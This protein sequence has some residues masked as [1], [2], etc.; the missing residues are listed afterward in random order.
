MI[1]L[2]EGSG[3][4]GFELTK[5]AV[6]DD[7]WAQLKATAVKLLAK[8][9]QGRA[10]EFLERYPFELHD[11]TNYFG[12]EFSVLYLSVG[13]E[14]YVQFEDYRRAPTDHQAFI[15]IAKT[16]TEISRYVRFIAVGLA[17]DPNVAP[18]ATLRPAITTEVVERALLD[19]E[20]LIR[21]S[22]P[23][24][25]VDRVHTAL[26]GYLR[27]VAEQSG[28]AAT[29]DDGLPR[30]FKLVRE[31][32]PAFSLSLTDEHAHHILQALRGIGAILDALSPLRNQGSMA[33]PNQ[34]LLGDAEAMLAINCGRTV[35][36][37]LDAK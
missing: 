5:P 32:H 22:G 25:A 1:T 21:S 3:A 7:E 33:H 9:G 31:Q 18:V 34:A 2:Y 13:L 19:A 16:V 4:G 17:S 12:D 15:H 26:H 14:D 35:L 8:R 23:V 6:S 28:I 24:S 20:S 10:A 37:Y 30:L 36:H 27:A 29:S 11:G